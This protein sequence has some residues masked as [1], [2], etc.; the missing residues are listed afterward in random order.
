MYHDS[1]VQ[2]SWRRIGLVGADIAPSLE[3]YYGLDWL[4]GGAFGVRENLGKED[5]SPG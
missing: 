3:L 1:D 4:G 5:S 2:W